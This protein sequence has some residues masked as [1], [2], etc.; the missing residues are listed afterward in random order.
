MRNTIILVLAFSFLILFYSLFYCQAK[1]KDVSQGEKYAH[2]IDQR[3]ITVKELLLNGITTD[4]NYKE[5]IDYYD[6]NEPP[7]IGGPEVISEGHLMPSTLIQIKKVIECTN[8][9]PSLIELEIEILSEEKY[10]DHPV[11]M[12]EHEYKIEYKN[13][14]AEINSEWLGAV[15]E[16]MED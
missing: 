11:R 14:K 9:L 15:P 4:R 3:Y 12:E 7:G 1:F 13:G 2:L 5:Q 6:L 10:R 8:C 16:R